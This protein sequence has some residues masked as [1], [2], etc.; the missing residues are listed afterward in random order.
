MNVFFYHKPVFIPWRIVFYNVF[1]GASLGPNIFGTEPW[2]F[3]IRNL[4]LNF[5][6]WLLLALCAGPIVTLQFLTRS[7]STTKM[8]LLRS[9]MFVMPFYLWLTLFSL[10]PHKEERFMYPV[11]PFL[12]LN[13]AITAH[14]ILFYL[15]HSSP[16]LLTGKIPAKLRLLL[17]VGFSVFAAALGL[18]RT[19]GTVTAYHAPLE[20]YRPLQSSQYASIGGAVC[21]GKEWYR[22]P[23]SYFLPQ[24]MRA[25]FIKSAFDGLLPGQFSEASVGFG[26]FPTWLIPPGMN[27]QNVEDPGKHVRMSGPCCIQSIY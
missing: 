27:D 7:Y 12:C 14:N 20:I 3:Y 1:R 5:N 17:V 10:Q 18:L 24:G 26:L 19:A 2:H 15:G 8:S 4:L 25:R 9:F 21:L 23:S 6:I 13:A 22:Y 11:Y 16:E